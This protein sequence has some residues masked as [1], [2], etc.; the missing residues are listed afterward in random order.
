MLSTLNLDNVIC[1]LYSSKNTH[2]HTHTHVCVGVCIF[3]MK[4]YF[5]KM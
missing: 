2:T 4:A 5:A 3:K 1:Q